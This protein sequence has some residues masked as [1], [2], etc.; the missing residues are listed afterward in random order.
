VNQLVRCAECGRPWLDPDERWLA[1]L[2]VGDE[3]N[4]EA[5]EA[6]VFC[7]GCASREFGEF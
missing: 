7:P 2:S 5:L 4:E 6:A 3:G 1:P